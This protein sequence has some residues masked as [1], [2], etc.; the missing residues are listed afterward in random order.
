MPRDRRGRVHGEVWAAAALAALDRDPM[1]YNLVANRS[2]FDHGSYAVPQGPG[3]GLVLDEA[4][5]A[6]YRV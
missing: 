2:A 6:K 4:M 5:I 3:F 1:F